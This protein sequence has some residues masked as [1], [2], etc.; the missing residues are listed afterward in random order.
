MD[1]LLRLES[2]CEQADK[3]RSWNA[4]QGNNPSFR[5]TLELDLV[6][7]KR[8]KI[9][10]AFMSQEN[11]RT[12]VWSTA[13]ILHEYHCKFLT[14]PT[15]NVLALIPFL[16]LNYGYKDDH[17]SNLI[18]PFEGWEDGFGQIIGKSIIDSCRTLSDGLGQES[19]DVISRGSRILFCLISDRW[20]CWAGSHYSVERRQLLAWRTAF[21]KSKSLC[22]RGRSSPEAPP[23]KPPCAPISPPSPQSIPGYFSPQVFVVR[24]GRERRKTSKTQPQNKDDGS[25]GKA[26]SHPWRL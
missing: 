19:N 17:E 8:R 26:G 5:W 1:Y 7:T 11:P 13:D 16:I 10:G 23:H 6:R 4:T 18:L 20:G 12:G 21:E 15:E 25:R 3:G 9:R 2:L 24:L 14:R 22:G